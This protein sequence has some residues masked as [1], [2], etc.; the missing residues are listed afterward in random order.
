MKNKHG[1][2][3]PGAGRPQ[4]SKSSD[5]VK[6]LGFNMYEEEETAIRTAAA[7]EG[8]TPSLFVVKH[9]VVAVFNPEP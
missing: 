7:A 1:G 5:Q 2:S 4:G 9:A 8:V 6:F 3:R